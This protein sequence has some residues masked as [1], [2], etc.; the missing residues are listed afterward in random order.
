MDTMNFD[1]PESMKDFVHQQ[2]ARGG[3]NDASDYMRELILA[4]QRK[5]ELTKLETEIL[6]GLDGGE[7]TPMTAADWA[8]IRSSLRSRYAEP[9]NT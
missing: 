4:D 8:E 1:L 2:V 3:F 5:K 9:T 6:K 7:F